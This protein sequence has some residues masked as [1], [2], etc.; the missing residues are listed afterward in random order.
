MPFLVKLGLGIGLLLLATPAQA[1]DDLP[2]VPTVLE[3]RKFM[4]AGGAV[5]AE[6]LAKHVPAGVAG[7]RDLRYA[8]AA[9]A[10]LDVFYPTNAGEDGKALPTV[11]WIHGGAFVAGDKVHVANYLRIVAAQGFTTV[12][13]NYSLAPEAR[14]P[15]PVEEAN[16][17]LAYLKENAQSLH[18]DPERIFLAGD[19]A[20]AQIA[21]QLMNVISSPRY[22][23]E[24][25]ITPAIARRALRGVVLFC[26]PY[27]PEMLADGGIFGG[28]LA[29]VGEA[30]FGTADFLDDP[31][32][33]EFSIVGNITPEVPP[34]FI[35]AGNGD[36]L[37]RH[38]EALTVTSRNLGVSVMPLLFNQDYAP[39]LP[40]EYQFD[41][42]SEAGMLAL[43]RMLVFLKVNAH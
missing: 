36:P 29:V 26:G 42:D 33:E 10:L 17:A 4:N 1:D 27:D 40:H 24:M 39:P 14:Y 18:I 6:A 8:D 3:V 16:R 2:A 9:N 13:L 22:A 37:A 30:Y 7:Q 12:G 25:A 21:A 20:G 19:S 5:A 34:L 31:R 28:F 11:V 43:E 23:E 15:T 35:S 32:M 41:L 38:A